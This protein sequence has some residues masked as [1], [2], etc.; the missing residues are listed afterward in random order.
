[1]ADN[2]K[3]QARQPAKESPNSRH[4]IPRSPPTAWL[5]LLPLPTSPSIP[6]HDSLATEKALRNLRS[7]LTPL[8]SGGSANQ[9]DSNEAGGDGGLTSISEICDAAAATIDILR[10]V[11]GP[12]VCPTAKAVDIIDGKDKSGASIDKVDGVTTAANSGRNAEVISRDVAEEGSDSDV[13]SSSEERNPTGWS[14]EL[15]FARA[16]AKLHAVDIMLSARRSW[17]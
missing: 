3:I 16:L 13:I 1:M 7:R 2:I 12:G 17:R 5:P 11:V 8:S 14:R 9:K 4:P 10:A 15:E 6:T